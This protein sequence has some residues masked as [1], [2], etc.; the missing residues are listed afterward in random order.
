[1]KEVKKISLGKTAFSLEDD[2]YLMLSDYISAL[3][4]YFDKESREVVEDIEDRI[5][6]LLILETKGEV[7]TVEN[8][9]KIISVLGN[10]AE[11]TDNQSSG[12][13]RG[14]KR[15][16]RVMSNKILGG[17]LSGLGKYFEIDPT[18]LR[19][20]YCMALFVLF[21]FGSTL[22]RIPIL[23]EVHN[24]I[25]VFLLIG[26]CV[27]WA[28]VPKEKNLVKKYSSGDKLSINT[29][30]QM[31]RESVTKSSSFISRF[32]STIGRI[33]VVCFGLFSLFLAVVVFFSGIFLFSYKQDFLGDIT[34]IELAD[35]ISIPNL[36][37]FKI[38]SAISIILT[39]ITLLYIG[40]K[41]ILSFKSKF[42][43]GWLLFIV[44]VIIVVAT[45]ICYVI[46]QAKFNRVTTS[47]NINKEY[48]LNDTLV[49][50][51][52][53]Y[54]ID[55]GDTIKVADCL[56]ESSVSFYE[57]NSEQYI[58]FKG[59]VPDRND[60]PMFLFYPQ[61]RIADRKEGFKGVEAQ[62]FGASLIYDNSAKLNTI[63]E[64]NER[65][66]VIKPTIIS[67]NNKYKGE[68]LDRLKLDIEEGQVVII[69]TPYYSRVIDLNK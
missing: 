17:V 67:K 53:D 7:V 56:L 41:L 3:N 11:I 37:M 21:F 64:S 49:I 14:A 10:P 59:A 57:I 29:V 36:I 68:F 12:E 13:K 24:F 34:I 66:I 50:R 18:W 47:C 8:V 40:L 22:S 69:E 16:E 39:T 28:V 60:K 4:E 48:L 63:V 2:A 61:L 31:S 27:L 55:R 1:M 58:S 38:L 32:L 19:L 54:F 26:Y 62:F 25:Y 33:L 44:N 45:L 42:P 9:K 65:E 51:Y 6:E 35:Y 43:Y 15:L 52:A 23:K 30:V 20:I 46:P 5:A